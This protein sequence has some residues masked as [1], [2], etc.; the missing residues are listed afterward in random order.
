MCFS[1]DKQ[2]SLKDDCTILVCT[3]KNKPQTARSSSTSVHRVY[4]CRKTECRAPNYVDKLNTAPCS[5][6]NNT[7]PKQIKMFCQESTKYQRYSHNKAYIQYL[8][9]FEVMQQVTL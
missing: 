6:T 8:I 7:L 5:Y 4:V 1:Q 9:G 3:L 2:G